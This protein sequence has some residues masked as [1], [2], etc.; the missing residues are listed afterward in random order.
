MFGLAAICW[1]IW[2]SRNKACFE[3]IMIKNP[4]EILCMACANM[5]HW[6]GLF[7][8]EFQEQLAAGMSA[9]LAAEYKAMAAQ[10]KATPI[11]LQIEDI[12]RDEDEEA[13]GV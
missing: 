9:I 8:R 10:N 6:A 2:K 12:S 5:K 11:T 4:I 1:S 7:K 13:P 3:K